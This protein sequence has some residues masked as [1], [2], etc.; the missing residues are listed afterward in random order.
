[1]IYFIFFSDKKKRFTMFISKMG[2]YHAEYGI[3]NQDAGFSIELPNGC[4][5]RISV[6]L[7]GCSDGEKSEIGAGMFARIF[8]NKLKRADAMIFDNIVN[9]ASDVFATVKNLLV[10]DDDPVMLEKY[11]LFTIMILAEYKAAWHIAIC[12]DGCIIYEC[13]KGV[14]IF[15]VNV[16]ASNTP[17]YLA[18]RYIPALFNTNPFIAFTKYYYLKKYYD[19]IGIG[20]DGVLAIAGND[21]ENIF[22]DLILNRNEPGIKRFI[23]KLNYENRERGGFFKD[24]VTLAI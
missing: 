17:N 1:M 23:N 19:S 7:D 13:N 14:E 10:P 15:P 24:D 18:Y 9:I 21:N 3:N 20:S 22:K 4:P 8:E 6:I 11:M 12:G 5:D 2:S 16:T